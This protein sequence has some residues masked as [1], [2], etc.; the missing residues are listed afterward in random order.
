MAARPVVQRSGGTLA[1]RTPLP[2]QICLAVMVLASVSATAGQNEYDAS[3][4]N[5][6]AMTPSIASASREGNREATSTMR[7]DSMSTRGV[8]QSSSS[9]SII[10]DLAAP[11]NKSPDAATS[12][13][14][15]KKG[16]TQ[17]QKLAQPVSNAAHDYDHYQVMILLRHSTAQRSTA[18]HRAFHPVQFAHHSI[19]TRFYFI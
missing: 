9:S 8:L 2:H 14:I 1:T 13:L 6:N 15:T 19:L 5:L 17:L 3:Q 12:G 11:E 10:T 16:P 4:S 7:S 18:Q